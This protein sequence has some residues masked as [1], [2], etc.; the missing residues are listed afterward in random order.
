MKEYGILV[1][2]P[3][4]NQSNVYVSQKFYQLVAIYH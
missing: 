3:G 1:A 4:S 2:L